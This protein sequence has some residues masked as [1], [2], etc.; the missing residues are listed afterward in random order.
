[1]ADQVA[2]YG[3]TALVTGAAGPWDKYAVEPQ[4]AEGPWAKYAAMG[5]I[6]EPKRSVLGEVIA[7]G[8]QGF[9]RGLENL[10]YLPN[11]LVNMATQAAGYDPVLSTPQFATLFNAGG[12][13]EG[14]APDRLAG[15]IAGSIGE[16]LG[17]SAVPAGALAMRGGAAVAQPLNYLRDY[18]AG[19]AGAGTGVQ[20]ARENGGGPVSETLAGLAGGIGGAAGANALAGTGRLA[21]SAYN[22]GRNMARDAGTLEGGAGPYQSG[23][24]KVADTLAEAGVSPNMLERQIAPSV[25]WQ[26]ATRAKN[27]LTQV[28]VNEIIAQRLGG[29]TAVDIA[30]DYGI[31]PSTVTRYLETYREGNITPMSILDLVKEV[32]GEGAAMPVTRLGKASASLSQDSQAAANL[33]NRQLG[34]QGRAV[35]I[36]QQSTSEAELQRRMA[37]ART[38]FQ[39]SRPNPATQL[40]PAERTALRTEQN[41]VWTDFEAQRNQGREMEFARE[42]LNQRVQRQANENYARLHAQPDI[43]VDER[44]GRL[45][46]QPLARQQWEQAVKLADADGVPIP[47]Y[48]ELTRTF[49]IRPRGGLGL[50]RETGAPTAPEQYPTA[51]PPAQPGAVVPVRALDYFQR[52]LRLDARKGGTE[53]HALNTIRQRLIDTL[54]PQNPAP[55]RTPLV[56]GFRQTMGAY[57]T[58]MAGDEAFAAGEAMTGRA[59]S[60][61]RAALREF[62]NM[63]PEQQHLFRLGFARKLMDLATGSNEGANAVAKFQN[64]GWRQTIRRI[65]PQDQADALIRG[66]RREN[67]TT[68]TRNDILRGSQTAEKMSDMSK[69]M[70]GAKAAA[71]FATASPIRWIENLG[72]R[73]AYQIGERQ[74][75][76]IIRILAETDPPQ[77]L[78]TLN[79]LAGRARTAAE[80]YAYVTAA[81][82]LRTS[83]RGPIAAGAATNAI[84]G[85]RNRNALAR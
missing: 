47:S 34:Q 11:N 77:L 66:M 29:R 13:R 30:K 75:Q 57:R 50:N 23:L 55:G 46:A 73:L 45:L 51:P 35:D 5:A 27:P 60:P 3:I 71:D 8:A 9:N 17:A 68:G 6:P 48:D 20:I 65:F 18:L 79:A 53:G 59:S 37:Q 14:E 54:D 24:N 7:Q 12:T 25:S 41:R 56:P 69:L 78:R 58:G 1:M 36:I 19:S 76:E 82:E 16:Q 21:S 84:A 10:Y 33:T 42:D 85:D 52:A 80:R 72:N 44:L 67:I 4:T 49:G 22:Y 70:A 64:E 40:T 28:D 61:T 63:T 81:K 15:R 62:D 26:L 32:R 39:A 83:M 2:P 38:D 74:S 31:A 43:V